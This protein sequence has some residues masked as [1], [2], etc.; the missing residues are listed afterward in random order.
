MPIAE[1][2]TINLGDRPGVP[3]KLCQE[4][5]E[6]NVKILA[7]HTCPVEKEEVLSVTCWKTSISL[8]GSS[9]RR[10]DLPRERSCNGD[11]DQ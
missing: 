4:P 3:G 2:F 11:A 9:P 10:A 6:Q 8:G 5:A 7:F 1:E